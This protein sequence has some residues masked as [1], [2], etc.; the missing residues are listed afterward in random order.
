MSDFE[1]RYRTW[2][3]RL[4]YAKSGVRILGCIA[5]LWVA[6]EPVLAVL[7][8]AGGLL[9]AEILGILEELV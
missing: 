2:H 4:S 9:A 8:L 6:T 5:A 7:L 1:T 3:T